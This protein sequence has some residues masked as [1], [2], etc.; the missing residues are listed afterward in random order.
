M[1]ENTPTPHNAA[2]HGEIAPIVIMS[3]DPLR[4]KFIA[5]TFLE[6]AVLYNTVRGMFGYTGTY[7]GHRISVQGH[8]MGIPSVGIYTYELFHFYGVE[9]IIRVGT[10]GGLSPEVKIGSIV[11]AQG[12]STDSSYGQHFGLDGHFSAIADFGLL[13]TAAETAEEQGLSYRAGNVLSSDIFYQDV[14]KEVKWAK[15]GV[16]GVEMESYGLYLNA[17]DAGKKALTIL[18]VSDNIV[19]HEGLSAEERQLGMSRMC[20]LALETAIK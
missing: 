19:T 11:L 20:L 13:K 17:A 5:E 10:C 6:D 18:T 9:K 3:G 2:R 15:F 4:A 1:A 7:K 8:G 14:N 12:A 16:I